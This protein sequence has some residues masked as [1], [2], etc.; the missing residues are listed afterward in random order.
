MTLTKRETT[1]V[2]YTKNMRSKPSTSS[3]VPPVVLHKQKKIKRT[4]YQNNRRSFKA[5]LL[6]LVTEVL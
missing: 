3:G 1:F 4:K 5:G 6:S 2:M